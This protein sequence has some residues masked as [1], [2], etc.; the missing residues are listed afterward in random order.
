MLTLQF[1]SLGES[2]SSHSY[3]FQVSK[4]ALSY[5]VFEVCNAI[6]KKMQPMYLKV[7]EAKEHWL[8][9][10]SMFENKV[11]VPALSWSYR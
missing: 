10:A 6:L 1:L 3:Q 9:M 8:E 4:T 5:I 7:S 11:A 2:Y